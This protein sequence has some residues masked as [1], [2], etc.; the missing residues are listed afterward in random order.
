MTGAPPQTLARTVS[1]TGSNWLEKAGVVG[2]YNVGV[3]HLVT[4]L[5][6]EYIGNTLSVYTPSMCTPTLGWSR[7]IKSKDRILIFCVVYFDILNNV[8]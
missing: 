1:Q 7:N 5:E 6:T 8:K 2:G 4:H 3:N